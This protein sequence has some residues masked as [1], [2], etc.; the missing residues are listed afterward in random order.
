M[1]TPLRALFR[2]TGWL[3]GLSYILLLGVAMPLK[4]VYGEPLMVRVVGMAHGLLFLAYL[5][6]AFAMYDRENWSMKKLAG[7]FLAS[8]L[9]FGPFV[10][11]WKFL[12]RRI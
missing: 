5:G 4:Y 2:T 11:D 10:F 1:R 12:D 7:A 8:L 9:P 3:E 6:L